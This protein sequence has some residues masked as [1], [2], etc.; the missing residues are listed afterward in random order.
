M[1]RGL[2]VGDHWSGALSLTIISEWLKRRSISFI[3][4]V[5]WQFL[6]SELTSGGDGS[7]QTDLATLLLWICASGLYALTLTRVRC[8]QRSRVQWDVSR[9]TWPYPKALT[10]FCEKECLRSQILFLTLRSIG[11]L[12]NLGIHKPALTTI[13][14]SLETVGKF[15]EKYQYSEFLLSSKSQQLRIM[16]EITRRLG[17]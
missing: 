8:Q 12:L 1:V 2:L 7:Y 5:T 10:V 16:E 13:S 3:F 17:L 4:A 6:F 11:S 15:L 14:D 9:V